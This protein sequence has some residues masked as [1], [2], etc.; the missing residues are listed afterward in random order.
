[1]RK[2][3]ILTVLRGFTFGITF[4]FVLF[5]AC[6]THIFYSDIFRLSPNEIT[7]SLSN[8]L[9]NVTFHCKKIQDCHLLP[10]DILVRRYITE[11]TRLFDTMIHPYFTHSA[12]YLGD[13]KI[14][15]A[16][17]E[18]KNPINDIQVA[19]FSK[20]DW[21]DE[22]IESFVVIRPK[23]Y[24]GKFE[25]VKEDLEKVAEDPDYRFGLPKQGEKITDCA[26]F[27][28]TPLIKEGVLAFLN[29]PSYINPDYLFALAIKSRSDFE[30]I[31]FY[32]RK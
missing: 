6:L 25:N 17:G 5:C 30:I 8:V 23:K 27:I 19:T 21:F 12:F 18:E 24:N 28:V 16:V 22:E 31:G 2:N 32:V 10:G 14:A 7:R 13:D 20:S 29:T 9:S 26:D 15:E 11:R 3:I 1:M 4:V